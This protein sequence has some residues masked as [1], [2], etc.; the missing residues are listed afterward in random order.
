[1]KQFKRSLV[2][3]VLV[4]SLL[5]SGCNALAL[6]ELFQQ[7]GSVLQNGMSVS[8]S[9]MEY[10][11]PD[12]T[13]FREQTEKTEELSKTE[14]DVKKLMDEVYACYEL[15]YDFYTNYV[16][17]NIHYCADVTD[18]YW[19]EEYQH[20]LSYTSEVDAA[21]DSLLYALADCTLRGELEKDDFFGEGF[22]SA[23]EGDSVWDETFT[24]L[25]DQEADLLAE[26]YDLSAE[27]SPYMAYS[28]EFF[29]QWG[30]K[31]VD[32]FGRLVALRQ[33]IAEYAGYE[34]YIGFAYD[35]YYDRDYTPEQA[36]SLIGDIQ[37]ELSPL[38]AQ[39]TESVRYPGYAP[40]TEA[41]IFAYVK[42]TAEKMGGTILDAFRLMEKNELYNTTISN[43]KYDASFEV[44][45]PNYFSP[46][47]FLNPQGIAMDQL[48]FAHEFGHFCN[49][50]AAGGTV[51]GVDV[52][53]VFSQAMEYLSLC[54]NPKGST[55][56]P[57][58]MA[59]TLGLFVEQSAYA[60]FEH[61]VYRLKGEEITAENVLAVY[62]QVGEEFGFAG[63][64][65]D[66]REFVMIPHFFTNPLYIISYVVS[67]DAAMQIY[68]AER[69]ET[70]AGLALMEANLDTDQ[71]LFLAFVEEAGLTS[72][73]EPGRAAALRDTLRAG[74]WGK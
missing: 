46:Y 8:F 52:A 12:L 57:T 35:F 36:V 38:Y 30:T 16:L 60:C 39:L 14:T 29:T 59:D 53:E 41:Q 74:I 7:I 64:Y 28:K 58:K 62:Q 18:I 68:Q 32:L 27:A 4:L 26:Y 33:E 15:Y 11:R 42:D 3:L 65:W 1:M 10:S 5:L 22:F 51:A 24:A 55:L 17:A 13:A 49:D 48:T 20:C 56:E 34:N 31:F 50:Y 2:A 19:D 44:F 69:K 67:A 43:K 37:K 70:G 72:P 9:D 45:L 25:M 47:V 73:F 40:C 21:M 66:A 23:Y 71:P 61:R 63:G 6:E 54:Y